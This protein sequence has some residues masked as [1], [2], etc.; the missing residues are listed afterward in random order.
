MSRQH[1]TAHRRSCRWPPNRGKKEGVPPAP[2]SS[3]TAGGSRTGA[4][5]NPKSTHTHPNARSREA[6]LETQPLQRQACSGTGTSTPTR[7]HSRPKERR[8]VRG[9]TKGGS[10]GGGRRAS[11]PPT[12]G[13]PPHKS[14]TSQLQ[15]ATEQEPEVMATSLRARETPPATAGTPRTTPPA[16]GQNPAKTPGK[17]GVTRVTDP[18]GTRYR[19]TRAPT[20]AASGARR[21]RRCSA[22]WRATRS[23]STSST[24]SSP[25]GTPPSRTGGCTP[26]KTKK[27]RQGEPPRT[28]GHHDAIGFASTS[29][30]VARQ[31]THRPTRHQERAS[32]VMTLPVPARACPPPE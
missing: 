7:G 13:T 22:T 16:G 18:P 2:S 21:N 30:K 8:R 31:P 6:E 11:N 10:R 12:T 14:P 26:H 28:A 19:A 15:S 17:P 29:R 24:A 1:S 27:Q 3:S 9:D 4:H 20:K 5:P 32:G 23:S 25:G